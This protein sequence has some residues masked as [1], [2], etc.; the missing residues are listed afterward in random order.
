MTNQI[1]YTSHD[2]THVLPLGCDISVKREGACEDICLTRALAV[3][4]PLQVSILIRPTGEVVLWTTEWRH[5]DSNTYWH[6]GAGSDRD[7]AKRRPTTEQLA[8][9]ER[10]FLKTITL[11]GDLGTALGHPVAAW[12]FADQTP[13]SIASKYGVRTP[14]MNYR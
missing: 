2:K 3:D 7:A 14:A 8:T 12:A 6:F 13:A 1:T 9:L 4:C 5:G 11:P 10:M